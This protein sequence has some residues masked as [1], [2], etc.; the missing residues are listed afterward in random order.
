MVAQA[1][2]AALKNRWKY[3]LS[4]DASSSVRYGGPFGTTLDDLTAA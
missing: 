2:Q 1:L 4:E 3:I